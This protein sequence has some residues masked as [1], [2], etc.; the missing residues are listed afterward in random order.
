MNSHFGEYQSLK[1]KKYFP[2]NH[3]KS[4]TFIHIADRH[5]QPKCPQILPKEVIK[6][7]D[8]GGHYNPGRD[9]RR[10][11]ALDRAF[12]SAPGTRLKAFGQAASTPT[13]PRGHTRP[14]HRRTPF[15]MQN[16]SHF[17]SIDCQLPESASLCHTLSDSSHKRSQPS[18]R[19]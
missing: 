4:Q 11:K 1:L 15:Q 17:C 3:G 10:K 2:K 9:R 16:S 12:C 19:R 5:N 13:D 8:S 6:E 7:K 18:R 14:C